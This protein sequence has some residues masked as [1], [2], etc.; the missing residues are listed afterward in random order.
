MRWGTYLASP[1]SPPP[2]VAIINF[3]CDMPRPCVDSPPSILSA[4]PRNRL[5]EGAAMPVRPVLIVEDNPA[6][7]HVM[8]DVLTDTHS[9]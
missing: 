5:H 9:M 3:V 6:I 8:E 7:R 2:L 4:A 1:H